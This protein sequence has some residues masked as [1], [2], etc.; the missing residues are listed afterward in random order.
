MTSGQ[1]INHPAGFRINSYSLPRFVV[2]TPP[3]V[4]R[5]MDRD[6]RESGQTRDAKRSLALEGWDQLRRSDEVY[7]LVNMTSDKLI[8]HFHVA[9]KEPQIVQQTHSN[10]T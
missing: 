5:K 9:P 7:W 2:V 8:I 10:S 4:S 6:N 1:T 3:D